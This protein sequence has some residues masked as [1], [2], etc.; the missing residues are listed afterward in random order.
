MSSTDFPRRMVAS[1]RGSADDHD[2]CVVALELMFEN[3][4]E[5][6]RDAGWSDVAIGTAAIKLAARHLRTNLD[7]Q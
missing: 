1:P 4:C 2:A 7:V 6:A 5:H 3:L